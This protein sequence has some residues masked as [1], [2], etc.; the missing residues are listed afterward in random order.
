MTLDGVVYTTYLPESL[1]TPLLQMLAESRFDNG[2]SINALWDCL[3]SDAYKITVKGSSHYGYTD[4]G[5]LLRHFVPLIPAEPLGFGTIDA[6][7]LINI[8]KSYEIAFF[9]VYLKHEPLENLLKLS[10][11][12]DEVTIDYK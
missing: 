4:V 11:M 3:S 2:S 1:D 6:K 5:L 10:S 8:T 7:R 12:F 9:N